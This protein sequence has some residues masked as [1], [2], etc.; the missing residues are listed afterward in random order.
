MTSAPTREAIS[1]VDATI[2][3]RARTGSVDAAARGRASAAA[4]RKAIVLF[5]RWVVYCVNAAKRVDYGEFPRDS[6]YE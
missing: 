1:D 4:R 3:C 5:I 2:A 6:G